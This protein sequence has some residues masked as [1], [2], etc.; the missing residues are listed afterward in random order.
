MIHINKMGLI[1]A[2]AIFA[3]SAT[4]ACSKSDAN[5]QDDAKSE[6][7]AEPAPSDEPPLEPEAEPEPEPEPKSEAKATGS[8]ITLPARIEFGADQ[9][10]L[11]EGNEFNERALV[12]L[13]RFLN[14]NERISLL[15]IEGH[16]DNTGKAADKLELSGKRALAV[17]AWLVSQGISE[18]KLIAV[19]FG[20]TKPLTA[21][22]TEEG[23]NSN[24]RLEFEIA[25]LDGKDYMGKDITD[26]G[27]TFE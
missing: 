10:E 21:N 22:T 23:R 17:K 2:V 11:P 26:G 20:G 24:N 19:G 7:A 9:A 6:E 18:K 5:S 1:T 8:H 15:R 16:T 13:R 25:G 12:N 14:E 4:A 3:A 27:K